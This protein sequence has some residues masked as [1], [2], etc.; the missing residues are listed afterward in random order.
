MW[1][2]MYIPGLRIRI[3]INVNS[4]EG[5]SAIKLWN[6]NRS[7]KVSKDELTI[8][9]SF[10]KCQSKMVSGCYSLDMK[11]KKKTH[12]KSII[13]PFTSSVIYAAMCDAFPIRGYETYQLSMCA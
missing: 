9:F 12:I 10:F 2:C 1:S 7:V 8:F 11:E 3:Q 13:S 5:L 6:Y 4:S